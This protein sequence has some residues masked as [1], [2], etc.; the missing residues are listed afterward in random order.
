[1]ISD[2]GELECSLLQIVVLV[3]GLPSVLGLRT[4]IH[5]PQRY[6]CFNEE[7][8]LGARLGLTSRQ[9]PWIKW[10]DISLMYLFEYLSYPIR[11][12]SG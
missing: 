5:G 12:T 1:M 6:V 7:V 9:R 8:V 10:L 3:R 11:P 2:A 4:G